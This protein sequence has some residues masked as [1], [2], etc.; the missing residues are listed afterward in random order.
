MQVEWRLSSVKRTGRL[1]RGRARGSHR[2]VVD[3]LEWAEAVTK[4]YERSGWTQ[5]QVAKSLGISKAAVCQA[6]TTSRLDP[7]IKE[8]M[9]AKA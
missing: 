3:E 5:L 4:A 1:D 9:V 6:L 2:T 7:R 8:A